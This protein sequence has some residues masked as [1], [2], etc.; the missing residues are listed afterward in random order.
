ML[1]VL[2][3]TAA[4]ALLVPGLAQAACGEPAGLPLRVEYAESSVSPAI[5][6]EL[7]ARPGFV[8]ATSG[9]VAHELRAAGAATMYWQMR[10]DRLIGLTTAPADPAT[11]QAAADRIYAFA[12]AATRCDT[13]GIALNELQGAWLPTPW[14][15]NNA[16]YRANALA[17]LRRLHELGARPYLL[18]ITSRGPH[19]ESWEAAEWWRQVAAVAEIVLQVH[20][21]SRPVAASGPVVGSRR[22]RTAM[23][24]ALDRFEAIGIPTSRLGLL[25]GFQSGPGSGGRENLTLDH[26]LRVVKWESLAA[27]QVIAERAERGTPLGSQWSW[28]WGDFPTL[29]PVDFEKPYVACVWLWTRDPG[30]CDAPGRAAAAGVPFDASLTEGQL[31][32]APGVQCLVESIPAAFDSAGVDRL[33]AV[34]GNRQLALDLL[35]GRTLEW[36]RASVP[37]RAV[38][39]AERRIVAARFRGRRGEYV[40]ALGREK[41]RVG[42]ARALIADQLRRRALEAGPAASVGYAAWARAERQR[43]L[44]STSCRLDEVPGAAPVDPAAAIGFLRLPPG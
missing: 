14:S 3:A 36:R 33:A 22:R 20:F 13:P 35:F 42:I 37:W 5:R 10:L 6:T 38:V 4:A 21:D 8:L 28:G 16:Q 1:R 23:R 39:R 26:W 32:L 2:L 30:L 29:S 24:R 34:T 41:A 27:R 17:L 7:F 40:R 11:I 12:R 31:V 44:E 25:H 18:V 15:A 9:A 43:A 19:T